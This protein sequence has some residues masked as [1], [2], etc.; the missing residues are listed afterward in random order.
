MSRRIYPDTCACS[1]CGSAP[2]LD[3]QHGWCAACWKLYQR[4]RRAALRVGLPA[5][6]GFAVRR[7]AELAAGV[8]FE[9][10][11]VSAA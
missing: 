7:R 4:E 8:P 10:A 9:R 2:P 11:A 1:I 5:P 3:Y 6:K